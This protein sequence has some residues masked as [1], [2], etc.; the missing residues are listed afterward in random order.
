MKYNVREMDATTYHQWLEE[1]KINRVNL[2]SRYIKKLLEYI[3]QFGYSETDVSLN[4]IDER[5]RKNKERGYIPIPIGGVVEVDYMDLTYRSPIGEK[6]KLTPISMEIY[7][8]DDDWFILKFWTNYSS[9]G[10]KLNIYLCDQFDSL[11]KQLDK[12]FKTFPKIN[13]PKWNQNIKLEFEKRRDKLLKKALD[14]TTKH[15]MSFT[16]FKELDQYE[17]SL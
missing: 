12:C 6:R 8:F 4:T 9:S 11:M 2:E 3:Q 7:Q 15:I 14:R 10:E 16:T 17:D 1:N 13:D 5:T